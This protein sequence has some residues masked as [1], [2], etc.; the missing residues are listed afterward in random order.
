MVLHLGKPNCFVMW[1]F[2]VDDSSR[3]GWVS[4]QM[5]NFKRVHGGVEGI[6]VCKG[7][8]CHSQKLLETFKRLQLLVMLPIWLRKLRCRL[9]LGLGTTNELL[10]PH[11]ANRQVTVLWLILSTMRLSW[12]YPGAIHCGIVGAAINIQRGCF[13]WKYCLKRANQTTGFIVF[14]G[15]NGVD[16]NYHHTRHGRGSY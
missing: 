10:I 12:W 3:L 4:W 16:A 6:Q 7:R 15:A 5:A 11:L 1:Y 8:N 13:Y 2:R 9:S 14:I